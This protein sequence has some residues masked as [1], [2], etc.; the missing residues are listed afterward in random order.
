MTTPNSRGDSSSSPSTVAAVATIAQ[1]LIAATIE[2]QLA[3]SAIPRII[4]AAGFVY[5][6]AGGTNNGS[7][8]AGRTPAHSERC[9]ETPHNDVPT[10]HTCG[11]E[12]TRTPD[13]LVANEVRYQLR[14][15][16]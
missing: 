7:P 14:H 3:A 2:P 8:A 16:P 10:H 4:T 15:S 1:H 5:A 13:P 9:P 12:G 11:A 6:P